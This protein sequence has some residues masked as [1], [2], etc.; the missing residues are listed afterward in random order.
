MGPTGTAPAIFPAA[1]AAARLLCL[2][3]AAAAFAVGNCEEGIAVSEELEVDEVGD[4][5]G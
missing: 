4:V 3:I 2:G 1:I 5:D